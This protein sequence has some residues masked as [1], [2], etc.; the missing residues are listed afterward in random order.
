VKN[1]LVGKYQK[2]DDAALAKKRGLTNP[3]QKLEFDFRL[4]PDTGTKA[5]KKIAASDV[6]A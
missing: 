1:S 5:R 4:S 6:V 3:F 2:V